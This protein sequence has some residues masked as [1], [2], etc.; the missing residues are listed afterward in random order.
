MHDVSTMDER[1]IA[2]ER[3]AG[4]AHRCGVATRGEV[5]CTPPLLGRTGSPSPS[6][7]DYAC[8][9]MPGTRVLDAQLRC[10][11]RA[12]QARGVQH[13]LRV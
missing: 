5:R 1:R 8:A 2:G 10:W 7:A 12:V 4:V 13:S 3:A 11:L 6:A 9:A